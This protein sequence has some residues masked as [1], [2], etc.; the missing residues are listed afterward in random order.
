ADGLEQE[1]AALDIQDRSAVR[2]LAMRIESVGDRARVAEFCARSKA[3]KAAVGALRA[4]ALAAMLARDA[5]DEFIRRTSDGAYMEPV[6]V[7]SMR[8]PKYVAVEQ[9]ACACGIA[10]MIPFHRQGGPGFGFE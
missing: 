4:D 9:V 7:G 10:L 3:L 8:V 5:W 2:A 1:F 6:D